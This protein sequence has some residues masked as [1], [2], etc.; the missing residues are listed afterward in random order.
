M[1]RIT[2]LVDEL[3]STLKMEGR[4]A[5]EAVREAEWCWQVAR[6]EHSNRQCRLDLRAV[7]FLDQEG[8]SFLSHA[9][10][11]GA[12]FLS[13]GCMT[14]AYVEAITHSGQEYTEEKFRE[15]ES[16][17][18]DMKSVK[19]I[20]KPGST[21]MVGDGFPVRN[22]FPSQNLTEEISPF[23]LLDYAGPS[24]FA[25]TDR[26]RGVGEHPH[27]GFETV[28]IVYQGKVAHRDSAG[29]A[30]IIGPGDVQWM[31]AASGV[32]HEELHEQAWAKNGGT[33]QMIQLWVNLPK[34]LK[35]G[36]PRYQTVLNEDIPRAN[37]GGPGGVIRVIA[38]E[39]EGMKG[40]AKTF[41]P[42]HLFDLEL[43]MGHQAEVHLPVGCN[44]GLFVLSGE[45]V[46]NRSQKV[47][48]AEMA[49]CDPQGSHVHIQAT[50]EARVLVLS[51]EPIHEPVARMGPFVMNT[52]EELV[53]AV[54]DY[55]EGKMGHLH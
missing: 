10:Q 31:T 50:E 36:A 38:G 9:F 34:A 39:Y 29:N 48:E 46:L 24:S 7:T 37:L 11:Q 53:Q 35:M 33:L 52:E 45:L 6:R 54:N 40:P 25:P 55:R 20:Y 47:G 42:V 8:K 23:L 2:M 15:M 5:G 26:P 16:T 13:S 1:L 32:V 12:T 51:G 27:R 41:T 18:K 49:L 30:G 21:H 14:R 43:P 4:L 17:M 19:G 3:G 22:I 44:T 28:T